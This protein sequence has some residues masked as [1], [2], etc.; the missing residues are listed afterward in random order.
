[1]QTKEYALFPRKLQAQNT[2]GG[3]KTRLAAPERCLR[4]GGPAGKPPY[5]AGSGNPYGRYSRSESDEDASYTASF[6]PKDET[7]KAKP[8]KKEPDDL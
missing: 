3:H 5:S 8:E 6:K 7:V 1:M 2:G 4:C